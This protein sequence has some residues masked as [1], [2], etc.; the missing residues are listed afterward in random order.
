[1]TYSQGGPGYHPGQPPTQFGAPTQSFAKA[2]PGESAGPSKLP[3]YLLAA[4]AGLGLAVYLASFGPIFTIGSDLP[5]LGSGSA[6]SVGVGFAIITGLLAALLAGASLLPKQTS[7]L[8]VVAAISALGFLLIIAELINK[9]SGVSIGW[10]LILVAVFTALQTAASVGALLL[11]AGVITPPA[12][13]PKYEQPQYG[14]YG[15]GQYYGQPSH[16]PPFGGQQHAPQQHAPQQRPGYPSQYGAY[17]SGPS[18]GGF[19]SMA[20]QSGP[21]TPPTGFPSFSPP[22][23]SSAAPTAAVPAQ[24]G[25]QSSTPDSPPP[26]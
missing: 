25:Q 5:Q 13:R 8:P 20:P 18:T 12:P 19:P 10:G 24:P 4:V 9:P 3:A 14:Q 15:P 7:H 6:V 22:Q 16:Q 2:G 23:S 1:M 11:D 21:P 17:P 26:S